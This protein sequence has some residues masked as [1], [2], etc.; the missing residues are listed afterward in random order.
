MGHSMLAVGAVY[1]EHQHSCDDEWSWWWCLLLV[2][3]GAVC[4][5]AVCV[6][7]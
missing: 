2:F 5:P 7:V 3:P 6:R 1:C 4:S